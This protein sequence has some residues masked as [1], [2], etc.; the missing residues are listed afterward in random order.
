MVSNGNAVFCISYIGNMV[1]I[2]IS[3]GEAKSVICSPN[4]VGIQFFYLFVCKKRK[5]PLYLV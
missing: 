4:V 3:L 1:Y 5:K 2:T